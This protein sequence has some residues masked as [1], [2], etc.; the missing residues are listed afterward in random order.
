M[1]CQGFSY[2]LV[3]MANTFNV[4]LMCSIY[5]FFSTFP[6]EKLQNS[7]YEA[8]K[9]KTVIFTVFLIHVES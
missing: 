5:L 6:C 1:Y 7:Q 4:L 9:L 8:G 2:K 3:R